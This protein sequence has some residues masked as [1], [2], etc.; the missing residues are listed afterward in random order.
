M[1]TSKYRDECPYSTYDLGAKN[2]MLLLYECGLHLSLWINA[3]KTYL[4]L[5]SLNL[6]LLYNKQLLSVTKTK[7]KTLFQSFAYLKLFVQYRRYHHIK[8]YQIVIILKWFNLSFQVL[9]QWQNNTFHLVLHFTVAK[10]MLTDLNY[11]PRTEVL[12]FHINYLF[13][14]KK[15]WNNIN[16]IWSISN[17]FLQDNQ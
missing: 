3:F 12:I 6:Y 14:I 5:K 1:Q 17:E 7:M 13:R 10:Y 11:E 16:T 2:N 9:F 15:W 4:Y 8:L